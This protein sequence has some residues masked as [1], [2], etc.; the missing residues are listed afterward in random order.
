[1]HLYHIIKA[2]IY[3]PTN[4]RYFLFNHLTFKFTSAMT[5]HAFKNLSS[6]ERGGNSMYVRIYFPL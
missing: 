2:E 1:M 3:T 5:V 6:R 4:L